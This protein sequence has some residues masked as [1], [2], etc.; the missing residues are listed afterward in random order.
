MKLK[1]VFLFVFCLLSKIAISQEKPEIINVSDKILKGVELYENEKYE[2]A[3]KEF[4]KVPESDTAYYTAVVEQVLTYYRLK[5]YEEGIAIGKKAMDMNLYLSPE[6]YTNMGCCYDNLEKYQDAINLYDEGIKHFPKNNLL[7]FNKAFSLSKLEKYKESLA[8]YKKS[9]EMNPFHPG[10]HFALG[11]AAMNEGKTSLAMLAFST[12]ILM[13]PDSPTANSALVLLNEIVSTKYGEETKPKNIDVTD[14]D[15][16][17]DIDMLVANYVALDKKYK[18]KSSLTSNFV[19]QDYLLFDKLPD[20]PDNKGFWYKLYVPFYKKLMKDNKFEIFS[21]YLLQASANDAHKKIVAK[22][23]AQLS[24]FVDW[25]KENWDEMH[26]QYELSFNGKMQDVSVFRANKRFAISSIGTLNAAKTH[27]VGYMEGYH[28]NGKLKSFGK[29]NTDGKKEGEWTYYYDNGNLKAKEFYENGELTYYDSY[30]FVGI[31]DSHIPYKNDKINGDGIAYSTDGAKDRLIGFKEGIKEGNYEEYYN[32]GQVS[33]K[34][35]NKA[36]KMNGLVTTKYSGGEPKSEVTYLDGEKNSSEISYYRNGKMMQKATYVKGMLQGDYVSY[37]KNGKTSDS[38][39]YLND[40][41]I[42]KN[43][44]FYKNGVVSVNA[45][46]DE[47]GKLNGVRKEYDTDGKIYNE[48]EYRKGEI[49]AY[50]YYN[51]KG[52]IVKSDEKK[53][54]N[55]DFE[56]FYCTGVKSSMGKYGKEDKQGEWKF[57][58]HNGNLESV[59]SYEDGK[60]Q[61]ESKK[62]F[63][64]GKVEKIFQYKDDKLEGYYVEYYKNGNIYMHG[65]YQKDNQE[66]PWI[67][68]YPD[69][70]LAYEN[71]FL[72]GEKNGTQKFYDIKGRMYESEL[73]YTGILLNSITYDTLGN[74]IDSVVYTNASGKKVYHFSKGGPEQCELTVL[75]DQYTD[76]YKYFY[77]NGKLN[78]KGQFFNGLKNGTWTWYYW[79]G[80]ISSTGVYDYDQATGKWEYYDEDGKLNRTV[81]FEEGKKNGKEIYYFDNG[82]IE[83]ERQYVDDD[84]EGTC[85]YYCPEGTLEHK[86]EYLHGQLISYTYFDAN[87]GEKVIPVDNETAEIKIYFKSGKLAR[88]FSVTKGLYQGEYKRYYASGQLYEKLNYV[89]DD[90]SGENIYYYPNGQIKEKKNFEYGDLKG[91]SEDYYVDGKLKE[92]TNYIFGKAQGK[93]RKYDKTGKLIAVLTYN[94]DDVIAIGDK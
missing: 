32:N 78:I 71:Y 52:E 66:G 21:I 76:D 68:Y 7:V 57:Y 23:K 31:M 48:R 34:G 49:V 70:T 51:K 38:I 17:S 88:Q 26:R 85:L 1:Y 6:L 13:D 19:K 83:S 22:N 30:S 4:E 42:G 65:N 59:S 91:L 16:F 11:V 12:Y 50:K 37:Y 9:S 56:G 36:G 2:E 61:G 45:D 39:K 54:G 69:K 87:G 20:N 25:L 94:N 28:N 41:P 90:A 77:P 24:A 3:L 35:T 84:L 89:D 29:W 80:N 46:F 60:S 92:S 74:L 55:F 33:F 67:T 62:Y 8:C 79:N 64:N 81:I 93:C 27:Y 75:Y 86:R 58:D 72:A 82:K 53:S 15:D 73:Y 43:I 40:K 14:G 47:S 5:R 44:L 63:S 10:T 18:V